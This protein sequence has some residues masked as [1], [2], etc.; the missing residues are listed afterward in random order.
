MVHNE[1]EKSRNP[2][3]G[4]DSKSKMEATRG[5]NLDTSIQMI[6]KFPTTSKLD[7]QKT[8]I[9]GDLFQP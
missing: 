3:T 1:F 5:A 9:R 4:T 2:L 6:D 7:E 8:T